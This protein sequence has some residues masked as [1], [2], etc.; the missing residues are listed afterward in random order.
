[1]HEIGYDGY[2]AMEYVYDEQPGYAECDTLQETMRFRDFART[3]IAAYT[4]D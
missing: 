2:F 3:Q 1:M 4:W